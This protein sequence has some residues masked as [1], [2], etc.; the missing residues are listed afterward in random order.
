MATEVETA[1]P[2]RGGAP[3]GER[4]R[5][6]WP[7]L[8]LAGIVTA[9]ALFVLWFAGRA[10]LLMGAAILLLF[11]A[12]LAAVAWTLAPALVEQTRGLASRLRD[13]WT[14]IAR[15]LDEFALGRR[16][17][18]GMG[19]GQE[20][21]GPR[22]VR[23]V[24]S[25]ASVTV[26]GLADLTMVVIL[27]LYLAYEPGLHLRGILH[28]TPP[29]FAIQQLESNP[30]TPLAQRRAV[31]LPPGLTLAALLVM[32]LLGGVLGMLLAVPLAAMALVLVRRAYSEDVLDEDVPRS[33]G[34]ALRQQCVS[35]RLIALVGWALVT[36]SGFAG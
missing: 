20:G 11:V 26:G 34:R 23:Q 12:A 27:A 22:V 6:D 35:A 2:R 30:I 29:H 21:G 13:A 36:R 32:G 19:G 7:Y 14:E 8:V 4:L 15:W 18:D 31:D 9:A 25:A 1:L 3:A 17:P 28:L 5:Q 33:R 10:L 24:W 16:A